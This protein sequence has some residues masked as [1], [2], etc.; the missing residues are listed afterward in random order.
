MNEKERAF[1]DLAASLRSAPDVDEGTGFGKNPGLR[2][3]KKIFAMLTRDELVLK[4]PAARCAE[5]VSA[6][7]AA[8]FDRGQGHPMK[9]WITLAGALDTWPALA[10]EALAYVRTIRR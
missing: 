4:L 6:G 5:L 9:E 7:V 3:N 10:A 2:V 8:P 1:A